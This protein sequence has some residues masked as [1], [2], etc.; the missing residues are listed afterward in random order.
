MNIFLEEIVEKL[1]LVKDPQSNIDIVTLKMIRNLKVTDRNIFF[2]IYLPAQDYPHKDAL[3]GSIETCIQQHFPEYQVHAH[4]VV[5]SPFAEAPNSLLPQISNFIAVCSGKGGVGKSTV[6]VNL[7]IAL[8]RLGFKTGLLDADL[9]GPSLPTMLG[10]QNQR[11]QVRDVDGKSNW[12]P[13][14]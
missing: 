1:K 11:P 14:R 9:Y 7:A 5:K 4:F 8:Q 6:S 10:I 2:D 3:Y 12:F 13:L